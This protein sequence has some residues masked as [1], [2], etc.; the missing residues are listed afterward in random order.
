MKFALL[1][2][3]AWKFR[4]RRTTILCN[5]ATPKMMSCLGFDILRPF[6][7]S[8]SVGFIFVVKAYVG[9]VYGKF[10]IEFYSSTFLQGNQNVL[11]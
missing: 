9:A 8:S 7:G 1:K 4:T 11:M 10:V 6:A 3:W 5:N 2:N